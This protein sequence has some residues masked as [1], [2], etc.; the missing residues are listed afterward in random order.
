M[1]SIPARWLMSQAEL[2]QAQ[3]D[4]IFDVQGH[5]NEKPP[6]FPSYLMTAYTNVSL[7]PRTTARRAM[8]TV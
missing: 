7:S 8:I 3:R 5:P 1:D 2:K 4:G 6:R